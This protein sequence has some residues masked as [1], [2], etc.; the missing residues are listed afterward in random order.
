MTSPGRSEPK[1]K[2]TADTSATH[3]IAVLKQ[4][5]G[6]LAEDVAH[7]KVVEEEA[8]VVDGRPAPDVPG[9]DDPASPVPGTLPG[10]AEE[11]A[12]SG[13]IEPTNGYRTRRQDPTGDADHRKGLP[14]LGRCRSPRNRPAAQ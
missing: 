6:E 2:P 14:K 13:G 1:E 9:R 4:D 11:E 7:L 12:A 10:P 3:H 5:N 8:R